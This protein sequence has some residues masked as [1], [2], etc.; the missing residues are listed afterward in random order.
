MK[1]ANA[2]LDALGRQAGEEQRRSTRLGASQIGEDCERKLWCSL[3]WCDS[4][5]PPDG[6][7]FRL[8]RRGHLEE[9]AIA[10]DMEAAGLTVMTVDPQTMKQFEITDGSGHFVCKL[11]GV[12]RNVPGATKVWHTVEMKTMN[13]KNFKALVKNGVKKAQP[14]HYWQMMAGMHFSGHNIDTRMPRALY[15][16]VN[17][18]TDDLYSESIDYNANE[19]RTLED[20][21]NRIISSPTPPDRIGG[22]THKSCK[23]CDMAKFC[24]GRHAPP[25]NCRTCIHSTPEPEGVWT[26]AKH[27]KS[28]TLDEQKAGCD[29]HLYIAPLLDSWATDVEVDREG[30]AVMYK[31]LDNGKTFWNGKGENCRSSE[32]IARLGAMVVDEDVHAIEAAFDATPAKPSKSAVLPPGFFENGGDDIPF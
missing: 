4:G 3:R 28:L 21:I 7:L 22:P 27:N 19:S 23:F 15:I 11:D 16:A 6:R 18:N 29:D 20:K 5:E 17:K 30:P 13:D 26:C 9:E 10:K 2:M 25:A 8:F 24:H 1:V 12:A 14:K 31:A 32:D